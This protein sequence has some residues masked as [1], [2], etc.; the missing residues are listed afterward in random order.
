VDR[1]RIGLE[2]PGAA[3]AEVVVMGAD[4]DG[5]LR[6]IAP[7]RKNADDVPHRRGRRQD[8]HATAHPDR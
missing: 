5:L 4:R 3:E 1:F 2:G 8:V 7:T 6:Q